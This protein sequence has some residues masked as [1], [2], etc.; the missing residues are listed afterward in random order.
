MGAASR[1]AG[2]AV[3]ISLVKRSIAF[4]V[5]ALG[6]AAPARADHPNEAAVRAGTF[7][8]LLEQMAQEY[9]YQ[10]T[11]PEDE[12]SF[13]EASGYSVGPRLSGTRALVMRVFEPLN[14]GGPAV[15][16]FRGTVAKE[17][18]SVIDDL[19]SKGI[20]VTAFAENRALID[21]T[22]RQLLTRGRVIVTGHSLGGSL[23][24]LAACEL[25]S[26]VGRVV[27]F[28]SPGIDAAEA[29]VLRRYNRAHAA[30]AIPSTHYQMTWDVVSEAGE[31]LTDGTIRAW[32][33]AGDDHD[34]AKNHSTYML[35]DDALARGIV[36]P[37][38]DDASRRV[39]FVGDRGSATKKTTGIEHIREAVGLTADGAH[40][41][42]QKAG[43]IVG[44]KD[45][46][47]T[48]PDPFERR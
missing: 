23:A 45:V 21:K 9:A 47:A 29:K 39:I 24:Q 42:I 4:T 34:P 6:V 26:L 40:Q 7:D 30:R 33:L 2:S 11:I 12:R 17:A 10:E 8:R 32:A 44:P 20:G 1:A 38:H 16:A 48:P 14:R 36:V 31:A 15:V 22:L 5:L 13:L 28:H 19:D 25:P 27:T 37:V 3:R 41:T 43:M 46:T 35:A 18:A